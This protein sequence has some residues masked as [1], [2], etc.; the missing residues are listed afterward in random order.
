M[1]DDT[2]QMIDK[3]T[4][5]MF[6]LYFYVNLFNPLKDSAIIEVL[7]TNT[8]ER[9]NRIENFIIENNIERS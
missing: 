7:T 3:D 9:E 2:I 4:C 5:R 1:V 8:E 6:Q